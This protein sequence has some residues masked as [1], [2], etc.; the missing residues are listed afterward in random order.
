MDLLTSTSD[1]QS[2]SYKKDLKESGDGGD[3][4]SDSEGGSRAGTVGGLD[5]VDGVLE[6]SAGALT[7]GSLGVSAADTVVSVSLLEPLDPGDVVVAASG[8]AVA[9]DG[10][11]SDV[12]ASISIEV[13]VGGTSDVG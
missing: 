8:L 4:S 13:V 1:A 2:T 3:D 9:G 11:V 12:G 6:G 5:S 7:V 10:L